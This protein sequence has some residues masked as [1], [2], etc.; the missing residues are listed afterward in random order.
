MYVKG[1]QRC[2]RHLIILLDTGKKTKTKPKQLPGS[3]LSPELAVVLHSDAELFPL[4][5][6]H[7]VPLLRA[8]TGKDK[9]ES[10]SNK[11]HGLYFVRTAL[12]LCEN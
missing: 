1:F 6:A 11:T 2:S 8:A 10:Q 9:R 12:L 3:L 4:T 5:L 7:F